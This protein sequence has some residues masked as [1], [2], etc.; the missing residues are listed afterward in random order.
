[1][2]RCLVSPQ[3]ET[4]STATRASVP[5]HPVQERALKSYYL[6]EPPST[7][8]VAISDYGKGVVNIYLQASPHKQIGQITGLSSPQGLAVDVENNLYV[9]NSG[10]DNN[11]SI[12]V[13]ARGSTTPFETLIDGNFPNDVAVDSKGTVYVSNQLGTTRG[14]AGV[15]VYPKGRTMSK[16]I[17]TD[18]SIR[19]NF[20]V[21]V[22]RNHDIYTSYLGINGFYEVGVF[23]R[24]SMPLRKLNIAF[25]HSVAAIR[26]EADNV[27]V[28]DQAAR[29]LSVYHHNEHVASSVTPLTAA[30]NPIAFAHV[31]GKQ[32]V[33]LIDSVG[34]AKRIQTRSGTLIESINVGGQP[35]SVAIS[36][37]SGD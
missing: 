36:P 10:G 15:V 33:W 30:R 17:L 4:T 37:P 9:A 28:V 2:H 26:V 8:E 6:F 12:R 24:A 25:L 22:G 34:A 14:R 19:Q 1:L 32:S 27:V 31:P 16:N 21:A 23:P 5:V 35:V 11:G 18:S 7:R 13:Y 20:H 29:T 3:F